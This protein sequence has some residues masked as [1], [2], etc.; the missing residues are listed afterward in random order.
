MINEKQLE[1]FDRDGAVTIDGPFSGEQIAA[2]ADC[3]DQL[4]DRCRRD[5]GP[6]LGYRL[7]RTADFHDPELLDIIQH[8]ALEQIAQ[9]ALRA[10]EANF[11]TAAIAKTY[12]EPG[13]SFSFWEH[14]DIKYR[15][16][17]IDASPRR[18]I[19][20]ILL[21]L[22]DV[23]MDRAPMMYRPGSFRVLAKHMDKNPQYIDNPQAFHD[24]PHLNYGNPHALLA[25]A[26]QI[27]VCTTANIHGASV[28]IGTLDRKVIFMPF[29]PKG[30][31][32]RA[33]MAIMD[34]MLKWH[35]ELR[36]LLRPERRHILPELTLEAY[37]GAR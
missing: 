21:W 20:S 28:N 12:P 25:K 31:P 19:C 8:P 3:V 22:T 29:I 10:D 11:F 9:K 24:L 14:V 23:T 13:K 37:A 35:D 7:Q 33:N 36:P 2:A 26:G 15:T 5:G 4:L 27:T 16:C 34:K 1:A 6:D 30:Y 17:D 18:M 32:I